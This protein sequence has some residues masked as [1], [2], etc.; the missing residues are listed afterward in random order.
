MTKLNNSFTILLIFLFSFFSCVPVTHFQEVKVENDKL[1]GERDQLI[2]QNEKLQVENTEMKERY[3]HLND[4]IEKLK[5]DSLGRKNEIERLT[6]DYNK[7]N[8]RYNELLK[9]RDELIKGNVE[10]SKKMLSDLESANATLQD[11]EKELRQLEFALNEKKDN[12]D[13]LRR[14]LEERNEKLIE[15]QQ[16]LTRKDSLVNALKNKVLDAL[17]GFKDEGLT[18]TQKNGKVYVSLDE[19]LLF[20][21]G[22]TDVDSK[23][24]KALK[25]LAKVLEQNRDINIM[26]EGHTDNVPLRGGPVMKDNWDLSVLRAT[27]IV[28]ILLDNST[29]D[30]TRLT[31]AGRGEHLPIDQRNTTEARQKNRRTEIILTPKLDEL[32][33]ILDNQ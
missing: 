20:N 6:S 22:S 31:V 30:P 27:A 11:K 8:Y 1:T 12:L 13:E 10:N 14:E 5:E 18:V 25:K 7:L 4:D 19:K 24:V 9:S 16:I 28:R 23:G 2:S 26:I 21:S 32:F 3:K 17:L 33:Q 15:L 29:I